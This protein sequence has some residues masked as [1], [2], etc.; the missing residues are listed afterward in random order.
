MFSL[1]SVTAKADNDKEKE[2]RGSVEFSDGHGQGEFIFYD[3][4]NE[5][6]IITDY[7]LNTTAGEYI[8]LESI[9]VEGFVPEVSDM[10]GSLV[11]IVDEKDT[12]VLHDNPTGMFH[13][14]LDEPTNVTLVLAGDFVVTEQKE[15]DESSNYTYQLV[16][17]DGNFTGMISSESPFEVTENDTVVKSN[18]TDLMM[19]YS[20]KIVHPNR[21]IE[22]VLLQAI[23]DGRLAAEVTAAADEGNGISDVVSYSNELHVQVH[24]VMK[25]EFE[26]SAEGQNGQGQLLLI[27][28]QTMDLS[29]ERLKVRLNEQ[30]IHHAE[31][32]LEMIYGQPEEAC[33]AIL[34]DGEVQE[35]L[36]YLPANTL[37][38]VNVQG[39]DALSELLSPMGLALVIGAF[40]LVAIA[41]FVAF[42]KR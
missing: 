4:D 10:H 18:A 19:H 13:I 26:L 25:N 28:I 38:T 20:P 23:Q 27:Q 32:P 9:A 40:G 21:W 29:Q 1:F 7:G 33:Y 37:G 24:K 31:E 22:A 6:G 2:D 17:S 39:Y 30:V 41:G 34:D 35:M 36:V 11:K 14:F 3:L 12:I 5:T 16:V 42:R 15:L 8:L